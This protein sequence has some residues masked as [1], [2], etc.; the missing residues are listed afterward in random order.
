MLALVPSMTEDTFK[1]LSYHDHYP[2]RLELPDVGHIEMR[3]MH[4]SILVGLCQR[5]D[6][7]NSFR[8]HALD[9]WLTDWLADLD[10]AIDSM[11]KEI[12]EDTGPEDTYKFLMAVPHIP[13]ALN[14]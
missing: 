7:L 6:C 14:A 11:C 2:I 4:L 10:K 9:V 12:A 3:R 1:S 5:P 8:H 13:S